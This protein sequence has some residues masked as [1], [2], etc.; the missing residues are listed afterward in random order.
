M[1]H[2]KDNIE[3]TLETLKGFVVPRL[4]KSLSL[5]DSEKHNLFARIITSPIATGKYATRAASPFVSSFSVF[6]RKRVQY[7]M[8]ALPIIMIAFFANYS[9]TFSLK[10]KSWFDGFNATKDEIAITQSAIEAKMSLSKAQRGISELKASA[11]E[12]EKTM[13]AT[14]VSTR[15][16]EVRNKVAAL[17]K[18]NKITEAK[19]IVIDLEAALKADQLFAM[20]PAVADEV[21]AATDLRVE[22]EKKEVANLAFSATSTATSSIPELQVRLDGFKVELDAFEANASST[23]L[24]ADARAAIEKAQVYLNENKVEEAVI[25]LQAA[26]RI[27]AE[28]RQLLL[29]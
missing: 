15:S 5:S 8:Y 20:A 27:V 3:H 22:L 11:D 29:Q 26:E 2:K 9:D 1:L 28:L 14:Q 16:Q 10:L 24:I 18:E 4:K 25:T 17:V 23:P 19:E 12:G 21:F 13:L 6:F 7:G